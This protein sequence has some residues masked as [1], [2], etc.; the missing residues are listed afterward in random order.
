LVAPATINA[1]S[2]GASWNK[3]GPRN[4]GRGD[5]KSFIWSRI[6]G[7]LNIHPKTYARTKKVVMGERLNTFI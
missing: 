6:F 2:A 1:D 4:G 7:R 3:I 5:G